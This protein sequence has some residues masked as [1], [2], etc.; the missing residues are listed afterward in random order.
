[1][2]CAATTLCPNARVTAAAR[3]QTAA[4]ARVMACLGCT[5]RRCAVFMP[6]VRV[7]LTRGCPRGILRSLLPSPVSVV[8][9]R[10]EREG[11]EID[12]VAAPPRQRCRVIPGDDE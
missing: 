9:A 7:E 11:H 10:H 1:M 4:P 6:E 8:I 2:A 12:R 5:R 3:R